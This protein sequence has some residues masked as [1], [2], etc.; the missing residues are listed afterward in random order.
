MSDH[1]TVCQ[2]TII[3]LDILDFA[4]G[5]RDF[6]TLQNS[7]STRGAAEENTEFWRVV[8]PVHAMKSQNNEFIT[9]FA[10]LFICVKTLK[11]ADSGVQAIFVQD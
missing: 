10:Y 1:A 3:L 6:T 5:V 4:K 8:Y 11:H 2:V 9:T 7:I